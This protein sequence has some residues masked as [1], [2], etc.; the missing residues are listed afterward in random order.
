M[1]NA[2]IINAQADTPDL[3]RNMGGKKLGLRLPNYRQRSKS[4]MQT[5]RLRAMSFNVYRK[6]YISKTIKCRRRQNP[7]ARRT[8]SWTG[9]DEP[10]QREASRRRKR[11]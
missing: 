7:S 5:I 6:S 1:Q 4:P 8:S 11:S 3:N 9:P 10:C 2:D